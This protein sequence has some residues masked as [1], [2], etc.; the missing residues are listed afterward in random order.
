M[1]F[2]QLK[3]YDGVM[4]LV[5]LNLVT[6]VAPHPEGGS[7]LCFDEEEYIRVT[8]S[9]DELAEQIFTRQKR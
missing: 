3:R 2:V 1:N 6:A 5:N 7:I 4:V 8:A 9:M